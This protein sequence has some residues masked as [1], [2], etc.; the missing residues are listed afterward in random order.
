MRILSAENLR[1]PEEGSSA[2]GQSGANA[3]PKGVADAHPVNI[4]ELP[5][6]RYHDEGTQEANRAHDWTCGFR[7]VGGFSRQIRRVTF[8]E[9]LW[10]G[11]LTRKAGDATLPRKASKEKSGYPYRKPTQVGEENI[12][13]RKCDPSFRNSANWPRNFGI[14][15][16]RVPCTIL[17]VVCANELQ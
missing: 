9:V 5:T 7:H 1:F 11:S 8:P 2:Q 14:R 13:R 4:P 16:A 12:L 15:G 3:R 10:R 17:A 6:F